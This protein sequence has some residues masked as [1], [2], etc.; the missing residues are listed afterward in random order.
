M[1]IDD[2]ADIKGF[3]EHAGMFLPDMQERKRHA[4][5]QAAATILSGGGYNHMN[6]VEDAEL[7]LA[8]I[9]KR[10]QR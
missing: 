4:L 5:L 9:K 6:A 2:H 10:E 3:I 1:T 7:L 8:E